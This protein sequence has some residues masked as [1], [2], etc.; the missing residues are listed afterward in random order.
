MKNIYQKPS[1]S[2]I[3]LNVNANTNCTYTNNH[4]WQVCG[5]EMPN[6]DIVFMD[7]VNCDTL[8]TPGLELCQ[9]NGGHNSSVFG[10]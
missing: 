2:F 10:S 4:D 5:I 3:L 1:Y 6:G 7:D 8:P 9:F